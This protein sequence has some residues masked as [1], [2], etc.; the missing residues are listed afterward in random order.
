MSSTA[1]PIRVKPG[2]DWRTFDAYLFD[3]DGT[4]LNSRGRVHYYAFSAA[5]REVFGVAG[6]I[7]GV[8]WYGNTDVGI[9]RAALAK[10][11]VDEPSFA[12]KR[13]QALAVMRTEVE[14]GA[15]RVEAEL[16]PAIAELLAD[17][18]RRTKVLGVSSGN[19]EIIGWVKL[20]AAGIAENFKFGSFSDLNDTR[21]EIFRHGARLA[22]EFSRDGATSICFLGDTPSDIDAAHQLGLP[23]IAIATGIHKFDD[24]A[25]HDPEMCLNCCE[26]LYTQT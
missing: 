11:G 20:R 24:L 2:F 16:C 10:H 6:S 26:D 23:V 18:G 25:Q 13:E 7:D 17:L 19:L 9:L 15:A 5:M 3:I 8:P 1:Q 14:K 12:A 4:L 21:V 22:R